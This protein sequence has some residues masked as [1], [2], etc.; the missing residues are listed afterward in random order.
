MKHDS[1]NVMVIAVFVALLTGCAAPV[2]E[3]DRTG[4][5]SDYSRLERADD[6]LYLYLG[7]RVANFSRFR[8]EGPEI[9]FDPNAG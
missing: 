4:F 5:I 6:T 7:P 8:I 1:N 3:Q 9:L 2:T